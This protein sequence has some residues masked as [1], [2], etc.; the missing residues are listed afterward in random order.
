MQ[1]TSRLRIIDSYRCLQC[2]SGNLPQMSQFDQLFSTLVNSFLQEIQTVP[3]LNSSS[4]CYITIKDGVIASTICQES[5]LFRPLSS[6]LGG[7][8]RTDATSSI[9]LIG[10]APAIPTSTTGITEE[11]D[12]IV[13]HSANMEID[14]LRNTHTLSLIIDALCNNKDTES[15]SRSS[16]LFTE[17]LHSM[18]TS[19]PEVLKAA[20][21]GLLMKEDC[22]ESKKIEYVHFFSIIKKHLKRSL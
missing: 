6:Q 3:V 20:Y 5:H 16:E 19:T 10:K 18:R 11:S 1:P 14:N 8:A 12:L 22:K 21:N 13:D 9:T 2:P 4:T 15:S 7:G 17:L